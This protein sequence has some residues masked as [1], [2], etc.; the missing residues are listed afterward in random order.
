MEAEPAKAEPP[1][2]NRRWFRFSLRTLMVVM[3]LVSLPMAWLGSQA[4]MI[5]ERERLLTEV[6]RAGGGYVETTG[7]PLGVYDAPIIEHCRIAATWT[8]YRAEYPRPSIVR[9]WLGE[10]IVLMISCPGMDS[11]KLSQIKAAFP[12]AEILDIASAYDR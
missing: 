1:K 5:R 7:E 6:E 9:Q 11:A 8:S 3:A 2:R 12:E 10:K 4:N